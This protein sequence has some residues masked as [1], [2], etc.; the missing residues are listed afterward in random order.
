MEHELK[1]A[2]Y[3]AG[4]IEALLLDMLAPMRD[5]PDTLLHFEI[6]SQAIAG[7]SWENFVTS[8]SAK[9]ARQWKSWPL[10]ESALSNLVQQAL[11]PN[12]DS[13]DHDA[14]T[15][16]A[17]LP[18]NDPTSASPALWLERLIAIM[19]GIDQRTLE[20]LALRT[21]GFDDRDI[22]QQL[23]T[24]LRCIKRIT[25]EMQFAWNQQEPITK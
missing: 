11:I 13:T 24:G 14:P 6:D 2:I 5:N 20:I 9:E 21:E 18:A 1:P 15:R 17:Q 8:L 19:R 16:P 12:V 3:S 23:D 22:S 4:K 7:S 25:R 10:I